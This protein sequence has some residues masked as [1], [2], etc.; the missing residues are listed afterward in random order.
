RANGIARK[1]LGEMYRELGDKFWRAQGGNDVGKNMAKA[2]RDFGA[3]DALDYQ[4]L[5]QA[6]DAFDLNI[7]RCRYAEFYKKIGAPELGF[8]LVCSADFPLAEGY[9][10][11]VE[12][13]RTQTLMQGA[14][15]CDFRYALKR[16]P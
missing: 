3:D 14:S 11:V 16:K 4:V 15:H 10:A 9:G 5:K 7:T 2:F 13:K 12:L 6:P 1:A 8:L